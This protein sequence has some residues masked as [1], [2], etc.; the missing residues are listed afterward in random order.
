MTFAKRSLGQNFLSDPNYRRKI[1]AAALKNVGEGDTI[2]EIGPGRGALTDFLVASKHPVILVEKD[3]ALALSLSQRY[4]GRPNLEIIN[5]DFLEV[6][7]ANLSQKSLVVL[8]NLPYNVSTQILIQLLQGFRH[9]KALIL[10]FQKEV[11]QRCVARPGCKDF[12][13][14]AIWCSL[15]SQAKILFDVPP[16]AFVPRPKITSSVVEF[17][18]S[19]LLYD[20][21][22]QRFID[23]ARKL[24]THRRKKISNNIKSLMR[25]GTN[26]DDEAKKLLDRR[27]ES[28][29]LEEMRKLYSYFIR[30]NNASNLP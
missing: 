16:S 15:F 5:T 12:G 29:T 26:F 30:P 14:L 25:L 17:V 1:A 20:E 13:S 28:L 3:D 18:P 19:G 27:A 7:V 4:A 10:M 2:L 8:G 23:F 22:Q 6:D 11:S 9:A 21:G 24:F